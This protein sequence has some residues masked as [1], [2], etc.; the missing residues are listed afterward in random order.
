MN[1]KSFQAFTQIIEYII[2][3]FRWVVLF[4]AV[5]IALSGIYRVQSN[6]VAIVLRLGRLVGTTLPEQVRGPG[7]HFALPFFIDEVIRIP[8][9]TIHER[10]ITT[11]YLTWR[12]R[13][14]PDVELNGYLLTGDHYVVLLR[15][16]VLYQIENPV[17]YAIFNRDTGDIIDGVVSGELTRM[18]TRMD[19]DTVLT[20]GRAELAAS[21]LASS[22]RILDELNTGVVIAA[23]E[24]TGIV[25]PMETIF[26]FEE[27][28]SAAVYKETLIQQALE[29]ASSHIF[30][31]QAQ[32]SAYKQSAISDQ[33]QRLTRVHSEMAEFNGIVE[34]FAINPQL[35]MA[36]TFR[37]RIGRVIA[38]SGGAVIVPEGSE[39]PLVLLP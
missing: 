7:L 34:L 39:A 12:G 16:N 5:L 24:L 28:R 37:E 13:I 20:G 36:G 3:Y 29:F 2:K 26:Y 27:V 1:N 11:H 6:E 22:Q 38:Q 23:V 25:P 9:H 4:A 21:V 17:L 35:I 30:D 18:V 31:A 8:V 14:L 32:A 33:H 15:A 19:I 10:D